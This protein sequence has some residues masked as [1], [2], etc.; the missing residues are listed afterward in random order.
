[1]PDRPDEKTDTPVASPALQEL[2]E[3]LEAERLRRHA[4]IEAAE[5]V[6]SFVTEKATGAGLAFVG[7]LEYLTPDV[8]AQITASPET[9]A[10]MAG[11][12]LAFLGGKR[13]RS[14]IGSVIDFAARYREDKK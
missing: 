11:A 10:I 8:L 14:A 6:L 13:M 2:K 3:T 9:S 7:S 4:R 12:G 5:D 1:M